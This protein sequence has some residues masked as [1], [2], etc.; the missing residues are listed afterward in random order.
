VRRSDLSPLEL[1]ERDALDAM[2]NLAGMTKDKS[3]ASRAQREAQKEILR[4][5]D[6]AQQEEWKAAENNDEIE[7]GE[8]EK[9]KVKEK[10]KIARE[11]EEKRKEKDKEEQE[12][13]AREEQEKKAREEQEKKAREEEEKKEKEEKKK[14]KHDDEVKE[15]LQSSSSEDE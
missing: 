4:K 6:A 13:K 14:R 7:Q 11:Q 1:R 10:E 5:K 8:R 9:E 15:H 12:K 3:E 2:R